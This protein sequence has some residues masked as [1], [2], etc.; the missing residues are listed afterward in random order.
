MFKVPSDSQSLSI[1]LTRLDGVTAGSLASF[2]QNLVGS[3]SAPSAISRSRMALFEHEWIAAGFEIP[4]IALQ[5]DIS[6]RS[7]VEGEPILA[8][9]ED[10]ARDQ[11]N[12]GRLHRNR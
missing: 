5:Y 7:V 8:L 10:G 9:G 4:G 3:R 1:R 12:E 2:P 11:A 6:N